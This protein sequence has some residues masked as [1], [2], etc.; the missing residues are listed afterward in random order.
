MLENAQAEN[1]MG[2][3][4]VYFVWVQMLITITVQL[5]LFLANEYIHTYVCMLYLDK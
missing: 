2:D 4:I 3:F 1:Y 5:V